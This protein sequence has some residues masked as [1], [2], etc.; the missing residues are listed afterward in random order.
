MI[1]DLLQQFKGH[2]NIGHNLD[3]DACREYLKAAV[4]QIE[5]EYGVAVSRRDIV[6]DVSASSG[7]IT[8]TFQPHGRVI[9]V[10]GQAFSLGRDWRVPFY[11]DRTRTVRISYITGFECAEDLPANIR[12][13]IM[14]L[15]LHFMEHRGDAVNR[16]NLGAAKSAVG[17]ISDPLVDSGCEALMSHFRNVAF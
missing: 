11:G 6:E 3:D 14:K 12:Q 7:L 13:A 1:D 5:V 17:G 16:Q 10:N 15:S 9:T 8:P 2:A 4:S